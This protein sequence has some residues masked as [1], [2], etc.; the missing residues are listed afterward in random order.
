MSEV[1]SSSST[2]LSCRNTL[3]IAPSRSPSPSRNWKRLQTTLAATHLFRT[4]DV[5]VM[6][7]INGLL[8][9]VERTPSSVA[10]TPKSE[11]FAAIQAHKT[12]EMLFLR[13]VRGSEKDREEILKILLKDPRRYICATPDD[14]SLVN[15]KSPQGRTLL[16]EAAIHGHA[17][18]VTLL[19]AQGADW[20]LGSTLGPNEEETALECAS[21]WSHLSTVEAL[22]ATGQW[23][24]KELKSALKGTRST[25]VRRRLE[26]ALMRERG[27]KRSFLCF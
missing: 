5:S 6:Q 11:V 27:K 1:F 4:P 20:H 3:K 18:I 21:R 24:P 17:L 22:L 15:L 26:T 19:L 10:Q 13:T 2:L 16:Y 23:S 12:L 9:E 14:R 25:E 8:E 7:D